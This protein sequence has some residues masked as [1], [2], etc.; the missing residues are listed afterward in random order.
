MQDV[1]AIVGGFATVADTTTLSWS[2]IMS[3]GD[4][5]NGAQLPDLPA[6]LRGFG[7]VQAHDQFI[8]LCGGYTQ[9]SAAP[10]ILTFNIVTL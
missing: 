9:L 7:L 6:D 10:S 8:Y 4:E 2:L 1:L 3:G 5:C